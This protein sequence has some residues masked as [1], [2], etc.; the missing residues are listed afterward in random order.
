[1]TREQNDPRRA[2]T[3]AVEIEREQRLHTQNQNALSLSL[4]LSSSRSYL[5]HQHGMV[6]S[7]D[8]LEFP[9]R[10]FRIRPT[11]KQFATRLVRGGGIAPGARPARAGRGAAAP[12]ARSP[13]SPARRPGSAHRMVLAIL[14]ATLKSSRST[15][16]RQSI[17]IPINDIYPHQNAHVAVILVTEHGDGGGG[18]KQ[19]GPRRP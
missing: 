4:Y 17:R 5:Y 7:V 14:E 19:N 8:S 9:E 3:V 15:L 12:A 16:P 18:A 2:H 13:A 10:E 11:H 6:I 1:M